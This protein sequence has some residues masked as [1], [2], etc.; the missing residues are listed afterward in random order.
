MFE[1]MTASALLLAW[2]RGAS[3]SQVERGL[4]LLSLALPRYS[5]QSLE[6][7]SIGD[8]DRLLIG[9][10]R[11]LFGSSVQSVD[12][13]DSC[14][15]LVEMDFDL[16]QLEISNPTTDIRFSSEHDGH[17]VWWRLPNSRDLIELDRLRRSKVKID[18]GRSL[19]A[20]CL[21]DGPGSSIEA[22]TRS[23]M[24]SQSHE[25]PFAD[26][27]TNPPIEAKRQLIGD[28]SDEKVAEVSGLME[29]ADAGADIKL[30]L[31]CDSCGHIWSRPF[32]ILSYL[33]SELELFCQRML[34]DV[35]RLARAYGWSEREILNLSPL[36]RQVYLRM[37]SE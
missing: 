8:R 18:I 16:A 22:D 10:R 13:C 24:L 15:H 1:Q 26:N 35:H 27:P 30:S 14:E 33:W 29:A 21:A 11:S 31:Q 32:D 23:T 3:G 12:R 19:L 20:L 34:L 9:L 6:L 5:R 2:D 36:R 4:E 37:V 28:L 7:I 17:P 25:V